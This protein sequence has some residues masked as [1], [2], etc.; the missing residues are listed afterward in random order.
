MEVN[1]R[2]YARV[3][4][5]ISSFNDFSKIPKEVLE[6][7]ALLGTRVHELIKEE[8]Q[9]EFP[10]ALG[11]ECGY[12]ESFVRW[13]DATRAEFIASEKR[14]CDE[15]RRLTGCIDA[16]VKLHGE[17]EA[18]LV[19]F[20]TSAQESPITWPMQAHLY[21][22]LLVRHNVSVANRFLFIK[23]DRHGNMPNVFQY[24]FDTNLLNKC[25][26][27]VDEYWENKSLGL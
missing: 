13:K 21:Y 14:Y 2:R 11:K 9:G 4:E 12:M 17:D 3:S 20:K 26:Q 1:G 6:N 15:E 8:I 10:I 27:L 24:K 25:L 16:I 7:K 18:I 23:L 22:Y 19:D 5:V